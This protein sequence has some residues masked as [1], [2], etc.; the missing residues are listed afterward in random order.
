MKLK[1]LKK[2]SLNSS[3]GSVIKVTNRSCLKNG[4]GFIVDHLPGWNEL[5]AFNDW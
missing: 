2:V 3:H 4:E 5:Y 1:N